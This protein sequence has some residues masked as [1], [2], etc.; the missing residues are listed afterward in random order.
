MY[1][2]IYLS[3]AGHV[4]QHS[5]WWAILRNPSTRLLR[6][7]I[8]LLNSYVYFLLCN[9]VIKKHVYCLPLQNITLSDCAIKN[10]ILA[11]QVL[12][13]IPKFG[14]RGPGAVLVLK[15]Y[16]LIISFPEKI[17]SL[18][19]VSANQEAFCPSGPTTKE[20]SFPTSILNIV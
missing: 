17:L 7:M 20:S 4:S 9:S 14:G 10:L 6:G 8:H 5:V 2:P 15:A 16:T 19:G 3:G 1:T 11:V 13:S 12:F 18:S